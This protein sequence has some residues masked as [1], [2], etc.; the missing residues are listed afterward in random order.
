VDGPVYLPR[1]YDGRNKTFFLV[2]YARYREV[3]PRPLV[4]SVPEKEMPDGDRA[5]SRT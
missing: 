3:T 4:L 2:N 5:A 1:L